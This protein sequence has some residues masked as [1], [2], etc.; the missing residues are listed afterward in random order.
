MSFAEGGSRWS[1]GGTVNGFFCLRPKKSSDRLRAGPVWPSCIS[2]DVSIDSGDRAEFVEQ[3]S[4]DLI[5]EIGMSQKQASEFRAV[6]GAAK[7]LFPGPLWALP[8][9]WAFMWFLWGAM[10]LIPA[11]RL[12]HLLGAFLLPP[13]F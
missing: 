2:G 3:I 1:R 5:W 13:L 4:K 9:T 7:G 12:C 10:T 8:S 6:S 11:A